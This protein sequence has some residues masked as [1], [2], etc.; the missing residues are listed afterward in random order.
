MCSPTTT[1]GTSLAEKKTPQWAK[2]FKMRK[3]IGKDEDN[4]KI[5]NHPLTNMK[6]KP[7]GMKEKTNAEHWKCIRK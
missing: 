1:K 3:L 5:E 2:R 6:S 4:I 7:A